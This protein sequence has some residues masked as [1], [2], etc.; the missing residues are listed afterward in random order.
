MVQVLALSFLSSHQSAAGQSIGMTSES[1]SLC[2]VPVRSDLVL[3][4][5]ARAHFIL[6][7]ERVSGKLAWCLMCWT[8]ALI[9]KHKHLT[10]TFSL[11]WKR[12][13]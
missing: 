4:H 10:L 5:S 6:G 1:A 12:S 9:L 11:M 3:V 8:Q 13:S 7:S 2:N